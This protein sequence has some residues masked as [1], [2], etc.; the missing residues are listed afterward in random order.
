MS[1]IWPFFNHSISNANINNILED[2]EADYAKRIALQ[3]AQQAAAAAAAAAT[4]MKQI[5]SQDKDLNQNQCPDPDQD[6][7]T[8]KSASTTPRMLKTD[9]S[10]SISALPIASTSTSAPIALPTSL[11]NTIDT[12]DTNAAS[13]NSALDSS[14]TTA[15]LSPH[16]A[17]S[18]TTTQFSMTASQLL[19]SI[20]NNSP[21]PAPSPLAM[22]STNSNQSH[23]LK[24]EMAIPSSS[25]SSVVNSNDSI[26]KKIASPDNW[27]SS[28]MRPAMS[29]KSPSNTSSTATTHTNTNTNTSTTTSKNTSSTFPKNTINVYLFN[30]LL[31]QPNLLDE[32]NLAKNQK[33]INYLS[34]KDVIHTM[35]EYLLFSMKL[36]K[37]ASLDSIPSE[38]LNHDI[39]VDNDENVVEE[40]DDNNT[41]R[42]TLMEDFT[43]D[44]NDTHGFPRN[45][46][47]NNNNN[48]NNTSN[49]NIDEDGDNND[50][51]TKDKLESALQ[52]AS[53][54][55]EILILP[56]SNIQQT[57]LGNFDI[58]SKLWRG[59]MNNDPKFYF[60]NIHL[61][62]GDGKGIQQHNDLTQI[63]KSDSNN[64]YG[65]KDI[66]ISTTDVQKLSEM[67]ESNNYA[68]LR[69]SHEVVLFN[70]FLKFVDD[71]ALINIA[72]FMNFVRFEQEHDCLTDQFVKF[73]PYSQTV[74]DL[75]VR[76][77]STDKPYNSN[78]LIDILIDQ[79]LILK[80]LQICK[81]YY[82]DHQ[83]Q[84]NVCN[85]LNGIVGISS[86][87]GF[88]EDNAPNE[89]GNENDEQ[90]E[91]NSNN[92]N[93]GPNNLTRQLISPECIEE[94]LSIILK[95][96]NYGLVTIVS[97]IIEVIRKN[98]SDYD[99]FDWI[100]SVNSEEDSKSMPSSRDPI[101]LGDLLKLFSLNLDKIVDTYLTV[102]FYKFKHVEKLNSSIGDE[103][104]PLGYERFKIMEL[105]AELLHCSNMIL[106]NKSIQL[107][108]LISKRDSLRDVRK[109]E[110]LVSDAINGLIINGDNRVRDDLSATETHA[111]GDN[112]NTECLE[113]PA[114]DSIIDEANPT[115][116]YIE[117]P[118]NL[119]VGNFFKY[120]LLTTHAIPL[121]ALKL[122]KFPWNNFMHNVIFDLIQQIFN[123]RLANWDED[124]AINQEE[125]IFDD[126]LSLNK[127]LIWSLFGDY[128]EFDDQS[129][130]NNL[131]YYK[132]YECKD[133][134]YPGF[135][136]LS[137]FIIHC[138]N[139][140]NDM[141]KKTNF[142]FGYMGHLTLIAEEIHKFQSYVENFGVTKNENAFGLHREAEDDI[143][144]FYLKSSFYIF[145]ELYESIFE[146][147][148]NFKPWL[149]FVNFE[150]RE[151]SAMY[152]KVLG[153]PNDIDNELEQQ[154]LAHS[155]SQSPTQSQSSSS[156]SDQ[157]EYVD[158]EGEQGQIIE[159]GENLHLGLSSEQVLEHMKIQSPPKAANAIILDNGDSEEFRKGF[160]GEEEEEEEDD[161]DEEN[162]EDDD[163]P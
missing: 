136:N 21:S 38:Y 2:I 76:L 69:D 83:V 34:Q 128:A 152:N 161:D 103:I 42:N 149:D 137:L 66:N 72:G 11:L 120:Q 10:P 86:N 134:L 138:Y 58:F 148:G 124:R 1:T 112:E 125:T 73:I 13:N 143:R 74:C 93:I 40:N 145:N 144:R 157:D 35:L 54:V 123:G 55:S 116:E 41:S 85:L 87:I 8:E 31:D 63:S 108:K 160:E 81:H 127:I 114:N 45:T 75:L 97:V 141:Y 46:S 135:F 47:H 102:R 67:E 48:N 91:I 44:I 17:Y 64:L 130:P 4:K 5:Q 90:H 20:Q 80:L 53:V 117:V 159:S 139:L 84:D 22:F 56:N 61:V 154:S 140:S 36:S 79:K 122:V 111:N 27:A 16:V 162:E 62:E 49:T 115:W 151:I 30:K 94:M 158:S 105:I 163:D 129:D 14:I 12:G 101:Y 78:G 29:S 146:N 142:R 43:D 3:N 65:N 26:T 92:P 25:S 59:F 150:L 109:T 89:N 155:Q 121:I 19:H 106:M 52:R 95:Y 113:G 33:L 51:A 37:F 147:K 77:V 107:D 18:P 118:L 82:L 153:N 70:N 39:L 96:G 99:E 50:T 32:I 132:D 133:P 156:I 110:Q 15:S 24:P 131:S 71:L 126:N 68:T 28:P 7:G 9:S 23:D 98:N 119:S 57:L 60:K 6:Q 100:A 104:E 88:W